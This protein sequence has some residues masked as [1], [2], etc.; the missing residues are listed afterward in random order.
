MK[1][2]INEINTLYQYKWFNLYLNKIL[3]LLVTE[4]GLIVFHDRFSC[5]SLIIVTSYNREHISLV[6]SEHLALPPKSPVKYLPSLIT[7]KHAS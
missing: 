1:S 2:K 6:Y 4:F 3:S 5:L 7:A